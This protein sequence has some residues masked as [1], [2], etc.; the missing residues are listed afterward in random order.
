MLAN[1]I[2]QVRMYYGSGTAAHTVIQ[3]RHTRSA[4]GRTL[5]HRAAS[6]CYGRHFE[7]M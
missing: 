1:V 6:T 3:W 2:K 5:L 4:D 7:S